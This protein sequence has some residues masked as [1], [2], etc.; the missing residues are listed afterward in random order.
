MDPYTHKAKAVGK[1]NNYGMEA[2]LRLAAKLEE[3]GVAVT[4]SAI[5][6]SEELAD[7]VAEVIRRTQAEASSSPASSE[8]AQEILDELK[9]MDLPTVDQEQ[10]EVQEILADLEEMEVPIAN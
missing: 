10:D 1:L 9:S 2:R 3:K 8:Q 7:A 6:S 4:D 5:P